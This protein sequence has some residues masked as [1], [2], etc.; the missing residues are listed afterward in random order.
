[1][2]GDRRGIVVNEHMQSVTNPDV[3][4]AGD[5]TEQGLQLTPVALLEAEVAAHNILN[6]NRRRIDYSGVSG[7]LFTHPVLATVGFQE[8]EL[9]EQGI[10]Y[11]KKFKETS[12]WAP[13]RR[14]GEH[15]SGAKVLVHSEKETILGAHLLGQDSQ[16]VINIF[17]MAIRLGLTTDRLK[18]MVWSY[19]SFGYTL[20]RHLLT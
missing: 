11:R 4:A 17:G 15:A 12:G 20:L 14:I 3:F 7:V 1:V 10:P 8:K 16:E 2:Q 9:V 18:D 6:A 5:V 13:Y 19:P